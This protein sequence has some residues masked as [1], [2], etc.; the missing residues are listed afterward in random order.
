MRNVVT[1]YMTQCINHSGG[2]RAALDDR[3]ILNIVVGTQER[4]HCLAAKQ[5]SALCLQEVDQTLV[6]VPSSRDSTM[7]VVSLL[8]YGL[9]SSQHLLSLTLLR[10]CCNPESPH[11]LPD[12]QVESALG[13]PVRHVLP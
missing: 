12:Y 9:K 13:A 8:N 4:V 5:A 1:W 6:M 11:R 2:H 10:A 3:E 7:A